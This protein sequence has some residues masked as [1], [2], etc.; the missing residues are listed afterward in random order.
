MLL[1]NSINLTIPEI[2]EYKPFSAKTLISKKLEN[3]SR[4]KKK[5]LQIPVNIKLTKVYTINKFLLIFFSRKNINLKK[6]DNNITKLINVIKTSVKPKSICKNL[7][8]IFN[9]IK[10]KEIKR[11][12]S[13]IKKPINNGEKIKKIYFK[14]GILLWFSEFILK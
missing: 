13:F 7:K 11:N 9:E 8:L 2:S 3:P 14:N 4:L 1:A 10:Y 5:Q 12:I 6:I